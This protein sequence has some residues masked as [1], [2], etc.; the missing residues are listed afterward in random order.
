VLSGRR[1]VSQW[2]REQVEALPDDPLSSPA[3]DP[4]E[5]PAAAR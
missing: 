1:D 5:L 3:A 4:A 2:C